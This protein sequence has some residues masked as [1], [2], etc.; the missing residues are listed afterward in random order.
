MK[1]NNFINICLLGCGR[2]S[3]KHIEA[4]TSLENCGVKLISVCDIVPEKLKS[5]SPTDD[6][7][8]STNICDP[9]LLSGVDLVVIASESGLHYEHAKFFL[10]NNID[11][12]IEKP[13]TLKL[14]DARELLALAASIGRKIY[15]VKQNRFNS[16]V[17]FARAAVD[18]GKLGKLNI[19]T[20]RVRWCRTQKYYDQASWRGTWKMD[21]GVITNQ[22]IHHI[23]LLQYFLGPVRK[24]RAF[25][26]TYGANIE[27]E[28]SLVSILEFGSG[29]IATVEATTAVRPRNIEGSL[30]LIGSK[31]AI[32]IGG[33]AANEIVLYESSLHDELVTKN[34]VLDQNTDDVYGSGHL[35]VYKEILNERTGNPSNAVDLQEALKSLEIVHM[36][37]KSIEIN[38]DVEFADLGDGSIRLGF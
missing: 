33:F 31:G 9:K 28:D 20:V 8:T 17:Q 6:V 4:I 16:A 13:A 3:G 24:V 27:A 11:V 37:Y 1:T 14:T 30:S 5:F 26:A 15:V 18:S 29:A 38:S 23:D 22:A 25:D 21:G 12:L 19:G 36:M 7:Y 32:E 34:V 10:Q 35:Q 2:I